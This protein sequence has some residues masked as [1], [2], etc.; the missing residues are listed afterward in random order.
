MGNETI[1]AILAG[2]RSARMGTPKA[3]VDLAGAPM[4]SYP[5]AAVAAAELEAVV[6][7]KPES[8]L[9]ELSHRILTEAPEPVHPLLGVTT[10]LRELGAG[11]V[12]VV[13]CDMPFVSAALLRALAEANEPLVVCEAGGR[14][15]PLLGRYEHDLAEELEG[16]IGRGDSAQ[17]TARALGAHVLGEAELSNFGDPERLL[18]NVNDASDLAQAERFLAGSQ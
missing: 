17:E 16:A 7:A 10:A 1:A 8:E 14:L 4:I 2:G 9:P 11:A 18:F 5:L 15:H 6:V 3:I 13:P 12:L